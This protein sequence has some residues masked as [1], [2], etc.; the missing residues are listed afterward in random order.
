MAS[1]VIKKS[2]AKMREV[3]APKKPQQG[4]ITI[5]HW[6]RKK[7]KTPA[8]NPRAITDSNR[9]ALAESLTRFGYV[10]PIVVNRKTDNVISG[11]TRLELL[12][13][14]GVTGLD[15]VVVEMDEADEQ[16]LNV[17]LNN[18]HVRGYFVADAL[19]AVL[20]SI[21]GEYTP[22]ELEALN[23]DFIQAPQIMDMDEPPTAGTRTEPEEGQETMRPLA[24]GGKSVLM[25]KCPS[26]GHTWKPKRSKV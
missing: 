16:A 14:Q 25:N 9:D 24:A 2:S 8:Y 17:T 22:I 21:S 1:K 26:C 10:E 5:E 19:Q 13:E 7:L 6:P 20:S 23:L 15:V 18:E 3:T 12:D 4:R 11:N